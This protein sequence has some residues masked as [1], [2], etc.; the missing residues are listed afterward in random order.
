MIEGQ[1]HKVAG[2]WVPDTLEHHSS[3]ERSTLG[4]LLHEIEIHFYLVN[5]VLRGGQCSGTYKLSPT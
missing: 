4:L 5:L 2:A 1:I 3:S